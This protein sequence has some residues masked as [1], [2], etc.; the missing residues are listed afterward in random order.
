M[1]DN[2]ISLWHFRWKE[3]KKESLSRHKLGQPGHTR[4]WEMQGY[5][6]QLAGLPKKNKHLPVRPDL[7][8]RPIIQLSV[9]F[10][11]LTVPW[12]KMQ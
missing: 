12:G 10:G 4:G 7:L 5:K 3:N 2:H 1:R 11:E 6:N 9:Y 8:Q